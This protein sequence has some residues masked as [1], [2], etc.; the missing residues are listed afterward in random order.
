MTEGN[1]FPSDELVEVLLQYSEENRKKVAE[2][3]AKEA[4]RVPQCNQCGAVFEKKRWGI[5]DVTVHWG[6]ESMGKDTDVDKWLLCEDCTKEFESKC[7]PICSICKTSVVE[8]MASLSEQ[9][10]G[11]SFYGNIKLALEH[12]RNRSH[13]C[14]LEYASVNGR[15]LCE[16]CY[17]DFICS[18]KIPVQQRS[19]MIVSGDEYDREGSIS[20]NRIQA[21]KEFRLKEDAFSFFYE[22]YLPIE[23]AREARSA[24]DS[25]N[26]I[27]RLSHR[28]RK[29]G[30]KKKLGR[31]S[32]VTMSRGDGDYLRVPIEWLEDLAKMNK[33]SLD[34]KDLEILQCG[35]QV[36]LGGLILKTITIVDRWDGY[37]P[38]ECRPMG[39]KKED[40][41]Q[42]K[43]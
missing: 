41:T 37:I 5:T 9:R 17:E 11:C 20:K 29:P 31:D 42:D 1:K 4:K 25:K 19:Y 15:I 16:I 27:Y 34:L 7:D 10:P 33:V 8:V 43:A 21:C 30:Q 6:Y 13:H 40:E 22:H 24:P 14:G 18:F 2:H 38:D 26:R 3:L 36:R 32:Y 28:D 12:Y 35:K 23:E 39:W